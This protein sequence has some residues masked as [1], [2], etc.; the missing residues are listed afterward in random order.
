MGSV[1]SDSFSVI[2]LNKPSTISSLKDIDSRL[3]VILDALM[4]NDRSLSI[5]ELLILL[6]FLT[7]LPGLLSSDSDVILLHKLRDLLTE[8]LY[9]QFCKALKSSP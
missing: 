1:S 3:R 8:D 5:S 7:I 2:P 6:H 9:S 4:P